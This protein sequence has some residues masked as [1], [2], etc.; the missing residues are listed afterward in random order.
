LLIIVHH[1]FFV[2]GQTINNP[3]GLG[4]FS[5]RL[6]VAVSIFFVLSGYLLFTPYVR[7]LLLDTPFPNT[8]TFYLKRFVRIVPAYWV[9]LLLLTRIN[10]VNFPDTSGFVRSFFLVHTFTMRNVFTGIQQT[11]TL[12]I[13]VFFYLCL[14]WIAILI[15]AQTR[16]KT[17]KVKLRN[18]LG[19]LTVLYTF[20][21]AYRIVFHQVN[22]RQF[23]TYRILLPAH[24]DT[25]ALGML[26]ATTVTALRVFPNLKKR[27]SQ[28]ARMGP[29]FLFAAG[30]FWFWSTQIGWALDLNQ[31]RFRIDLLGHFL[32][33]IASVCFVFPFCLD[34]GTSRIVKIFGSRVCVWLGTISYGM[35]LWHYL[36]LDG[37][38]ADTYFPYRIGDMGI[39]TRLLVTIPGSIAIA[40]VSYYLIERPLIRSLSRVLQ[41][42]KN[43]SQLA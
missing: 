31:S 39:A 13:E 32:Y 16:N 22:M 29:V 7:A 36:F 30:A 4:E 23:E 18:I 27:H 24:L 15:R 41:K 9:A 1:L 8:H 35:Y 6:N 38:F 37:H 40:T 42:R 21:Y 2:S 10:A 26:I 33:G 20:A 14:P 28:L 5:G 17:S 25:F 12:A 34:Q 19:C 43:Q 11:W 3:H